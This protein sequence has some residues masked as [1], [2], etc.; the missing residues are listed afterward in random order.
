MLNL[1][2]RK[3]FKNNHYSG[4]LLDPENSWCIFAQFENFEQIWGTVKGS[5]LKLKTRFKNSIC[6][7]FHFS[8]YLLLCVPY[9][10]NFKKMHACEAA[11]GTKLG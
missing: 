7:A 8:T 4:N 9:M 5:T 6:L 11:G 1:L 10:Q 3:I 2:K